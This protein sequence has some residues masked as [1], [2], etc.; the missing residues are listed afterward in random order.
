MPRKNRDN[1]GKFLPNTPT[2]SNRQ[3][4][5]IFGG[6]ELEDPSSEQ[7]RYLKSLQGE[8]NKENPFQLT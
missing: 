3:H 4:S 6:Y 1:L 7:P 8:K 5:L 2:T